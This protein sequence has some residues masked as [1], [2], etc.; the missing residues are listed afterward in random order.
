[1]RSIDKGVNLIPF[2]NYRDAM[3]NLVA[4]VGCYC[5]YC[6]MEI[7][8]EPDIEHVQP[9]SNGG[10]VY[11]WENFLLGCKK[12]NDIKSNKNP[13]RN[14]YLWP[15][16]DNTSAAYE[17]NEIFVKAIPG[18]AAPISAYAQNTLTLTGID[19]VPSNIVKPTKKD[20]KDPRWQKRKVAWGKAQRAYTNWQ[21][22][23]SQE[24][25]E[26]IGELAHSSG[27]YSIWVKIFASEPLVLQ[28]IKM[29]YPSTYE[30][31]ANPLGGF[32]L[33]HGGRF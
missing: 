26:T 4:R 16:E 28:S 32:V 21:T 13:D 30:P 1:M 5:C 6:E 19:R 10:A 8:N 20:K 22:N 2:R 23:R 18:L 31:I 15:D 12:C 11:L 24:L 3:P 9:K 7:S 27:F 33:R 14:N 29:L 25:A 17:Y